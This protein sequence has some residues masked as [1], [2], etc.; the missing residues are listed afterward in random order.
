M[1]SKKIYN[2][3]FTLMETLVAI[4]LLSIA[5]AGPLT[6][7]QKGLQAALVSKDQTTAFFLAQDVIEFV[8]FAR[9]SNCL[10]NNG[11][12]TCPGASWLLGP[13]INLNSCVSSDGSAACTV[14][15]L[16][17]AVTTCSSGVC[18]ALNYNSTTNAY[19]YSTGA[20]IAAS[21]FTRTVSIK[22]PVCIG[23]SP[24]NNSELLLTVTITWR[25]PNVHTVTLRESIL[26]WQ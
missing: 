2:K 15:T 23:A 6:I 25:D 18:S 24:C 22:T 4:L 19:T 17:N 9:D 16:T 8:R 5:M 3:G 20:G 10:A 12:A 13:G 14:D 26:N 11:G 21:I 7:A 1:T